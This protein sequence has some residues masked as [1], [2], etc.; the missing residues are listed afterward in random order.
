M[1]TG[2]DSSL[3]YCG[4]SAFT[5]KVTKLYHNRGRG[6][7]AIRATVRFE[8]VTLQSGLGLTP[9]PGLG[10]LCA[11]FNGDRW[12]D[13]LVANDG[14]PNHSG[15]TS[16]TGP[17]RRKPSRAAS[18]TTVWDRRRRTWASRSATWI[19]DGLFDLFVTHLSDEK[20]RLWKQGPRWPVPRSH[21]CRRLDEAGVERHRLRHGVG[22]LRSRRAPWTWH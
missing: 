14:K 22:R 8:D 12:P 6:A 2:R 13:I 1:C 17:S 16:E 15:S 19:G 7:G 5:G 4:P 20:H 18:P 11:D 21:G 3:D 9:G 10:V